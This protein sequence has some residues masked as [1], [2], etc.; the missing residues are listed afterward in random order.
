MKH[1]FFIISLCLLVAVKSF[2]QLSIVD[3]LKTAFS[4]ASHDTTKT[5][6]ALKIAKTYIKTDQKQAQEYINKARVLAENA[7]FLEGQINTLIT[8][9][10]L[11]STQG[12]IQKSVEIINKGFDL[13]KQ[14]KGTERQA[15]VLYNVLGVYYYAMSNYKK[16]LEN[17]LAGLAIA[18]KLKDDVYIGKFSSNVGV[19]Y[20]EQGN[21]PKALKSYFKG[22]KVAEAH[23]QYKSKVDVL[24]NISTIYFQQQKL[25]LAIEN[26]QKALHLLKTKVKNEVGEVICLGNLAEFY[27]YEGKYSKALEYAQKSKEIAQRITDKM[28]LVTAYKVIGQVKTKRKQYR[29]AL[30]YYG[31]GRDMSIEINDK[32][33]TSNMER[34]IALIHSEMKAYETALEYARKSLKRAQEIGAAK[35]IKKGLEALS[36]IFKAQGNIDSSYYYYRAYVKQKDKLFGDKNAREIATIRA[37]FDLEKKQAEINLLTK[38]NALKEAKNQR[39]QIVRNLFIGG[40]IVILIIAFIMY[41]N[42]LQKQRNNQLLQN[43]NEEINRKNIQINAQNEAIT[44]SINYA[45]R[46][47]K[48]ILPLDEQ[49]AK[50]ADEY[51]IYNKPRDIVSG[52][53]YWVVEYQ[54]KFFFSVIDCTGHG[55]PGAFMSM[56]GN[57]SLT[58]IVLQQGITKPHEILNQLSKEIDFILQQHVTQNSDSM[59]MALCMVDFDKGILEYAGANN[60]M[61]CIQNGEMNLVKADRMPIGK[62]QID[63]ARSYTLHT[64]DISVPTVVYLFSDG[65]QDQFGGKDGKK[66]RSRRLRQLIMD[67]HRYP[68]TKQRAL[69]DESLTTWMEDGDKVQVDDILIMGVKFNGKSQI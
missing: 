50:L 17:L 56:L 43:K 42:I 21:Y 19:I 41:R 67:I 52:D 57:T 16:S 39:A 34:E 51:F 68:L 31:I 12:K 33:G 18:E 49:I 47:Q 13:I 59:D 32:Q 40:F 29:E 7:D 8:E 55:V 11:F 3:S 45:Q 26:A 9:A 20:D 66:F 62:E 60:P 22:L 23:Q 61:L 36:E 25:K 46:I 28:G 27:F 65:Y 30:R 1:L 6:I 5:F 38:D 4:N 14:K 24:T 10:K 58:N 54:N 35:E 44:S 63:M 37:E 69:L 48:A 15:M 64:I 53:F 2:A